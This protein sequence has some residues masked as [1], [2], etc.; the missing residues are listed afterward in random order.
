[1]KHYDKCVPHHNHCGCEPDPCKPDCFK[2]IPGESLLETTQRLYAAMNRMA[3]DYQAA[4]NEANSVIK[5][6]EAKS[7]YNGA[8]YTDAV[9]VEEGYSNEDGTAYKIIR[10]PHRDYD[11]SMIKMNL[12]LAYGNTTNSKLNETIFDASMFELADKMVTANVGDD[13][14]GWNGLAIWDGATIPAYVN[15]ALYTVGFNAC[16]GMKWY[17]NTVDMEQ[18]RRDKI[19]NAMG[20]T[21]ILVNNQ[22]VTPQEMWGVESTTALKTARIVMGQNYTTHEI[23]ILVVGDFDKVNNITDGKE[24]GITPAVAAKIMAGYCDVAVNVSLN[25]GE[26]GKYGVGATDKG[27][28]LFTPSDSIVQENYAYWFISK[29]ACYQNNYTFE[30]ATLTQLYGQLKWQY[31][32]ALETIEVVINATKDFDIRIGALEALTANILT[33]IDTINGEIDT[34]KGR[35][36][37][38]EQKLVEL[39]NRIIAEEQERADED[40]DIRATIAEEVANSVARDTA[41]QDNIDQEVADRKQGDATLN[42][43]ID[44]EIA[45]RVADV[46]K[47]TGDRVA[48]IAAINLALDTQ[49]QRI[50][51]ELL[52]E[53]NT[54][55][56]ADNI[57]SQR[58]DGEVQD[59]TTADADLS[60]RIG[61]VTQ[62]TVENAGEINQVKADLTTER[63]ERV[64]A[65]LELQR[66]IDEI[67]T[68]A[69][70]AKIAAES[71]A[72]ATA[73]AEIRLL[74]EENANSIELLT[75]QGAGTS[76]ALNDEITARQNAD[77]EL[78]DR[79]DTIKLVELK[80]VHRFL[81]SA[82]DVVTIDDVV[83]TAKSDIGVFT[84]LEF[85]TIN[86]I[87]GDIKFCMAINRDGGTT[88]I[89]FSD[90]P[91]EIECRAGIV[92]S[93]NMTIVFY[94]GEPEP[95]F[96]VIAD[97]IEE[98]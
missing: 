43:K 9:K 24:Y 87:P 46:N 64:D 61:E 62:I 90:E 69:Y 96:R 80:Q 10:I 57:L 5:N 15:P 76:E 79:I 45:D 75:V 31:Y 78:S 8:Y 29:K 93:H 16:N 11:G 6:I 98:S 25:D 37:V 53:A 13:V 94:Y 86:A 47:E 26:N 54:R 67:D 32:L 3:C 30:S 88:M 77:S 56:E 20:V 41:L 73:D 17:Q 42:T 12:H 1:M 14:N 22:V 44:Q 7:V 59:R 40:A 50:N 49:V 55:A 35:V 91:T 83:I 21:G 74:V 84:T 70:D 66:Q 85:K 95:A 23:V 60:Q 68:S 97:I 51:G 65:D 71:T 33:K 72:R 58:I 82:E 92:Y 4:I 38:A 36:T 39:E 52:S 63:A 19:V 18:L 89:T 28:M 81:F 27:A 2:P 48:D 34:L